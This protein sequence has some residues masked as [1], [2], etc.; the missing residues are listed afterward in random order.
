MF[1]LLKKYIFQANNW[2]EVKGAG[3][4]S[5]LYGGCIPYSVVVTE[6]LSKW[7]KFNVHLDLK[8]YTRSYHLAVNTVQTCL[9]PFLF[10]SDAWK[11]RVC[12]WKTCSLLYHAL[13][14]LLMWGKEPVATL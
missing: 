5:N 4:K 2:I 9:R 12:H 13:D 8:D 3:S 1:L 11:Q 6:S 10:T 7:W 14:A